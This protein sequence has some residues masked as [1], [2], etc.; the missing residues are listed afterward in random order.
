MQA[1][2]LAVH[3][4]S[5]ISKMPPSI[6]FFLQTGRRKKTT[7]ANRRKTELWWGREWNEMTQQSQCTN[8]VCHKLFQMISYELKARQRFSFLAGSKGCHQCNLRR[9]SL[10]QVYVVCHIIR[11]SALFMFPNKQTS[12]MIT[13]PVRSCAAPTDASITHADEPSVHLQLRPPQSSCIYGT[14]L[15]LHS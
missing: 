3:S 6:A 12:L 11:S 13:V 7:H 8:S 5:A 2:V 9:E 14:S 10:R 1:L 15:Q 4:L